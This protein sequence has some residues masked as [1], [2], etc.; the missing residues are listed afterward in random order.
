MQ[1]A[2][3]KPYIVGDAVLAQILLHVGDVDGQGKIDQGLAALGLVHVQ[4]LVTVLFGEGLGAVDDVRALV[5]LLGQ[6][7]G[8]FTQEQLAVAHRQAL[9]E[10][11]D[12]V[13]RIVQVELT[14]HIVTGPVQHG[15]QAVA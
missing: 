13:A 5:A 12:L 15:G 4:V 14:G 2:L 3:L 9:A 8:L 6:G 10:L 11:L 1:G 7:A